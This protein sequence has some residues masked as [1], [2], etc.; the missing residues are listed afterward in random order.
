MSS[1]SPRSAPVG[2]TASFGFKAVPAAARQGLVNEVFS[3]VADRYD[4]MNDL[5]SGGLHRVWKDDVVAWLAPPKSGRSFELIDVAGGTGD[6]AR[7]VLD[8]GGPGCCAV[9]C[10][11][12][13]AMVE[14]GRRRL[15]AAKFAQRIAFS[16]AN[17]ETLPF[18]DKSFDAYTIAFGIR[19]VTRIDLA[20]AE[21]YRLP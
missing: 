4:L 3:A 7:R 12:S 6:I 17:A 8:T 10:D 2:D 9:L 20:L 1:P 14:A 21:A 5:M 16:I 13:P 19:N 18:P 11:I 15:A